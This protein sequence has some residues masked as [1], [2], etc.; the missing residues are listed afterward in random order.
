MVGRNGSGKSTL[1]RLIL[2]EDSLDDGVISFPEHYRIGALDQHLNFTKDTIRDEVAQ[3]LPHGQEHDTS[4]KPKRYSPD[5]VFLFKTSTSPH[6]FSGG[7]QIRVKLAQLL[8]SEP[9]LLLLDEPTTILIFWVSA[10]SNDS[11]DLGKTK[12]SVSPTIKPFS[13]ALAP[14]RWQFI[15]KNSKR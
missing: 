7:F 11:S 10:G 2:G 4:V 14:I 5:L 15:E 3:S 6:E 13:N 12:S 9:N 1:F 8:L